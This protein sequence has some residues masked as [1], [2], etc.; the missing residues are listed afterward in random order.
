MYTCTA[1]EDLGCSSQ[2]VEFFEYLSKVDD[3]EVE[4]DLN[5]VVEEWRSEYPEV[6]EACDKEGRWCIDYIS[7]IANS[8]I[9]DNEIAPEIS[10]HQELFQLLPEV[11]VEKDQAEL[12]GRGLILVMGLGAAAASGYFVKK[13]AT[14]DE[15]YARV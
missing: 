13:H 7:V 11:H 15:E 10:S 12:L 5:E 6:F 14:I 2:R 9:H 8:E 3:H 4:G 1:S